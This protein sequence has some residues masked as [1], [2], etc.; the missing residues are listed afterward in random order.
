MTFGSRSGRRG[1]GGGDGDVGVTAPRAKRLRRS[2]E[3]YGQMIAITNSGKVIGA[4]H[5]PW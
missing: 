5:R 4:A 1:A 2:A 3:F